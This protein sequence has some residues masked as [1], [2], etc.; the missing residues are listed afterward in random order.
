[1]DKI[2]NKRYRD[3]LDTENEETT[4]PEFY[5]T[6]SYQWYSD[7]SQYDHSGKELPQHSRLSIPSNT[8]EVFVPQFLFCWDVNPYQSISSGF[9]I[10][11]GCACFLFFNFSTKKRVWK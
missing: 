5:G 9:F 7:N 1:L 3:L 4:Y 2:D 10:N 8:S 6:K 11:K